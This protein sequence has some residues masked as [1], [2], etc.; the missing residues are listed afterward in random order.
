M[1]AMSQHIGTV[2]DRVMRRMPYAIGPCKC[3]GEDCPRCYP[4]PVRGRPEPDGDVARRDDV[5]AVEWAGQVNNG[6]ER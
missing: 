5:E 6:S 3:G 1:K 2:I 4:Q